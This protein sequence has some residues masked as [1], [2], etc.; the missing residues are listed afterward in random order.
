MMYL[1]A[2]QQADDLI[3]ADSVLASLLIN[4][5]MVLLIAYALLFISALIS[6]L[7]SALSGG[8]K[9]VWVVV[10]FMAPFLGS[11]L[12]FVIGRGDAR[13]RVVVR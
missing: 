8:M 11:L 2:Q 6:I 1:I 5:P 12:W 7:G 9:L 10:A 3:P 4:F 13:R